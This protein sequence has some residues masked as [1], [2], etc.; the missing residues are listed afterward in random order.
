MSQT[1]SPGPNRSRYKA[2]V[3]ALGITKLYSRNPVVVALWSAIFPGMGH[4]LLD[5]YLIGFALFAWEIFINFMSHLNIGIFYSFIGQFQTA[6]Y[7]LD[8]QWL[9]LYC[10]TYVFIIWDSYR[11]TINMN[12]E[13]ILARRDDLPIKPFAMSQV[14]INSLEKKEPLQPAFWSMIVPGA[15]Q[16]INHQIL[17]GFFL[18]TL[19]A[20]SVYLSHLLPAVHF[21]MIGLFEKA[22]QTVDIH[23]VLNIPSIY[24]FSIYHAYV[25]AIEINKLYEWEQ[26]R[27]L[28]EEYSGIMLPAINNDLKDR[29]DDML[30]VTTF[31]YSRSLE[32]AITA[33]ETTGIP[34][35][36]IFAVPLNKSG[37]QTAL[38]DSSHTQDGYNSFDLPMILAALFSLFGLIYGFLLSLGPVL[39]ALIGTGAGFLVGFG[40]KLIDTK[41]KQAKG[42]N[43]QVVLI[44]Q[45]DSGESQ[46]VQNTLMA[47][48]FLKIGI[49][50]KT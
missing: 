10:P 47:Y 12:K 28:R 50:G 11:T 32:T 6:K 27:F 39:W 8:T 19:W 44:I 46:T 40:I 2:Y 7:S 5:K 17:L 34:K 15:G 3:H 26:A 48:P 13:F 41:K 30:I 36:H 1:H 33:I 25:S 49:L 38:L 14:C 9:L 18:V 4:I 43:A 42:K 31:D 29:S 16:M 23:W 24:F 45:C 37:D 21:T 22:K 35:D 20:A